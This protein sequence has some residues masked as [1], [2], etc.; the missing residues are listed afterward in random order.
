[1]AESLNKVINLIKLTDS[2]HSYLKQ[3]LSKNEC[4][5]QERQQTFSQF[6]LPNF[7]LDPDAPIFIE[8]GY[9]PG[10]LRLNIYQ[11]NSRRDHLISDTVGLH[12]AHSSET[13]HCVGVDMFFTDWMDR[14][15]DGSR[16]QSMGVITMEYVRDSPSDKNNSPNLSKPLT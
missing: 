6:D 11:C 4:N 9:G 16:A 2:T 1:M 13:I 10:G 15:L 3:G 14:R 8:N 12:R 5:T 7:G